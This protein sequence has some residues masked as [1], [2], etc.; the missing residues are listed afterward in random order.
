MNLKVH[1][2][3]TV[4]ALFCLGIIVVKP[5]ALHKISGEERICRLDKGKM[6]CFTEYRMNNIMK[7]TSFVQIKK[8]EI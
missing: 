8:T 6:N 4:G 2:V 7:K 3:M 5:S 1:F